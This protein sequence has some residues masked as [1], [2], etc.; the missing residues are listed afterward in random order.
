MANYSL[1]VNSKFRPFEFSEMIQP[2]MIAEQAHK[3]L[4]DAYGELAAKANIWD[5]MTNPETDK[6]A[7]SIYEA[8]A[9]DLE[10]QAEEL[11][12]YGLTP[13]SRQSMIDM[14]GRYSKD[15][16]PIETAYK[17]R[18]EQAKQQAEIMAKDPTYRFNRMASTT[19]LDNYISN[20]TFNVLE[21][22]YSGALLAKQVVAGTNYI[23]LAVASSKDENPTQYYTILTI[24]EDLQSNDSVISEAYL[25]LSR[26]NEK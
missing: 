5:K 12:K 3:E 8:Y 20:P 16:I 22:G 11:A 25:D 17:R 21:Q 26:Y 24:N 14:K 15:I 2:V 19:S 6:R 1:V 7:H 23:M 9:R 4:E 18:A 10:K 13:T